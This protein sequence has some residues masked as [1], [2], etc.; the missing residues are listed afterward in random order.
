M[1]PAA[2]VAAGYVPAVVAAAAVGPLRT[3]SAVALSAADAESGRPVRHSRRR[4]CCWWC[5]GREVVIFAAW[6]LAAVQ[7]TATAAVASLALR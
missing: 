5:R 4:C 2:I 1:R 7:K 3:L 6:Q